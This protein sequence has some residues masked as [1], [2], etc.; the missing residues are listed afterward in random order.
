ME[1]SERATPSASSL[2]RRL[3]PPAALHAP[4]MPRYVCSSM[5]SAPYRVRFRA[6]SFSLLLAS[7]SL[8]RALREGRISNTALTYSAH[9]ATTAASAL[10]RSREGRRRL[11]V[12]VVWRWMPCV[13][14]GAERSGREDKLVRR[15]LLERMLLER[16]AVGAWAGA[17]SAQMERGRTPSG[18][19]TR[20]ERGRTPS[21]KGVSRR[22]V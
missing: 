20:T 2:L 12:L 4:C 16:A 19:C 21:E 9:V 14:L 22:P 3:A 5:I 13:C 6:L 8:R 1:W 15:V 7:A 11:R 17:I 10:S 18:D